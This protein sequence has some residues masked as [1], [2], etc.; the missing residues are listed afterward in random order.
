MNDKYGLCFRWINSKGKEEIFKIYEANL[1]YIDMYTCYKG[2]YSSNDLY[3]LLPDKIKKYINKFKT[4]YNY[5]GNFFIRKSCKD[6]SRGRTD[7]P[8]LF[9]SDADIVYAREDD[10]YIAFLSLK[11]N[12]DDSN[13]IREIKNKFFKELYEILLEKESSLTDKLDKKIEISG[14]SQSR[15]NAVSIMPACLK[16]ISK[17]VIKKY[18]LKRKVVILLK[19][20]KKQ[21]DDLNNVKTRLVNEKKLEE[22]TKDR[23]FSYKK[24]EDNMIYNLNYIKIQVKDETKEQIKEKENKFDGNFDYINYVMWLEE[25]NKQDKEDD[26]EDDELD[27]FLGPVKPNDPRYWGIN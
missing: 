14:V 1:K 17:Y 4:N 5:E 9:K 3:N 10:I 12:K 20:Y 11:K 19:S 2:C 22:R 15:I 7:L 13:E 6:I 25:K 23:K 8:I 27:D 16:E 26:F 18:E 24:A 21:L